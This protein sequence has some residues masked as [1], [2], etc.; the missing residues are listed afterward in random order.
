MTAA[1]LHPPCTRLGGGLLSCTCFSPLASDS[2]LPTS[3]CARPGGRWPTFTCCPPLA[4]ELCLPASP[5]AWQGGRFPSDTFR[6]SLAPVCCSAPY[7]CAPEG[8]RFARPGCGLHLPRVLHLWSPVAL[9][10]ARLLPSAARPHQGWWPD[11]NLWASSSF[12]R[13]SNHLSLRRWMSRASASPSH[14][15]SC[16]RR[17]SWI[18]CWS[19]F[20]SPASAH[21]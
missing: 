1:H 19:P 7:P 6:H 15:Q 21:Q 20:F 9:D 4:A 11:L 17:S 13:A 16:T 18:R 12:S 3:L 14:R 10:A 5:C 2:C 8:R